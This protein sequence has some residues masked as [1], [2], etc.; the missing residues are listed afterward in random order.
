MERDDGRGGSAASY[1]PLLPTIHYFPPLA[2]SY[3][4]LPPTIHYFLPLATSSSGGFSTAG[5]SS[6]LGLLRE[7]VNVREKEDTCHIRKLPY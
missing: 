5:A 1:T 3:H 6:F 7:R 4:P 2:A